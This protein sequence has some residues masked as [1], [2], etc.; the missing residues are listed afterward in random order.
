MSSRGS[1]AP[2][3]SLNFSGYRVPVARVHALLPFLAPRRSEQPR[4]SHVGR[5][6]EF[7][8]ELLALQAARIAGELT[9]APDHPV[10]RDDDAE[11]IATDGLFT[12]L[13]VVPS[14]SDAASSP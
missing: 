11:R 3:K 4:R 2:P 13:A 12:S 6:F 10:A 5:L 1:R 7:D 8:Q 9:V 14:A